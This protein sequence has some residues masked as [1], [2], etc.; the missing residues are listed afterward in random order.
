[1][2]SPLTKRQAQILADDLRRDFLCETFTNHN[3]ELLIIYAV[4]IAPYSVTKRHELVNL[5]VRHLNKMV[6]TNR[7]I[8]YYLQY[9]ADLEYTV[10][11]VVGTKDEDCIMPYLYPVQ[12]FSTK[13]VEVFTFNFLNA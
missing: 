4:C 6:I 9:C 7:D 3:G 13:E 12:K 2:S 8:D 11:A 10:V 5:Y 1:M